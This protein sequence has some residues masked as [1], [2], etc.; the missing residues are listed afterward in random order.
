MERPRLRTVNIIIYDDNN[1]HYDHGV[2]ASFDST[3][4]I[5]SVSYLDDDTAT[6]VCLGTT[7]CYSIPNC[8]STDTIQLDDTLMKRIAKFNKEQEI[9]QL[10]EIIKKKKETIKELDDNLTDKQKRW[11]KVK[12]F[13]TNIY[14]LDLSDDYDDDYYDEEDEW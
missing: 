10:D 9:K 3:P 7:V 12:D 11:N 1:I 2:V 5:A 13:I 6:S 14:D 4:E 8:E